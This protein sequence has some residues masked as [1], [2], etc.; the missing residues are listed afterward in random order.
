MTQTRSPAASLTA[1]LNAPP[2]QVRAT[3][4]ALCSDSSILTKA[5]KH[6]ATLQSQPATLQPWIC[7]RCKAA[8][9]ASNNPEDA[10]RFHPSVVSVDH[11]SEVW[12]DTDDYCLKGLA[13]TRI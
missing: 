13:K 1:L 5:L 4:L 10:C 9:D 2:H 11:S 12:A 6:H 3:L 7:V 8:F